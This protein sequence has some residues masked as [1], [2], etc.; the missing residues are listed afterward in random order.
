MKSENFYA[1]SGMRRSCG[2]FG[3]IVS[4][5]RPLG[6]TL[7]LSSY[8]YDNALMI[9]YQHKIICEAEVDADL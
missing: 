7:F 5:F 2:K 9:L 6:F 4:G 8:L 3:L 1:T